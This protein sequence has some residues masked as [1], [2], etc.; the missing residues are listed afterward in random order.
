MQH[1]DDMRAKPS[2]KEM[3]KEKADYKSRGATSGQRTVKGAMK[4]ADGKQKKK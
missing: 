4:K 1:E 2:R 3:A